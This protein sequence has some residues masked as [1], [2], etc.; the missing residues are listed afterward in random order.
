M[1]VPT[2]PLPVARKAPDYATGLLLNVVL[3]G[4]GFSYLGRWGWNLSWT[5]LLG[6]LVMLCLAINTL[7]TLGWRLW[8]LPLLPYL[9]MLAHYHRV[10]RRHHTSGVWPVIGDTARTLLIAGTLV[11]YLLTYAAARILIGAIGL[12][13]V[14]LFGIFLYHSFGGASV[15]HPVY[16]HSALTAP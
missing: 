3:P 16:I 10:Y 14:V 5:L 9:V 6:T 11:V 13:L 4:S 15:P 1:T 2:A 8:L 7:S 12:I